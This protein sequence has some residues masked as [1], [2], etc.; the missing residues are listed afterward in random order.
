MEKKTI[1]T[2][3]SQESLHKKL[4][5]E[6]LLSKQQEENNYKTEQFG[7]L[8]TAKLN[9][10]KKL[11]NLNFPKTVTLE[12]K[13]TFESSKSVLMLASSVRAGWNGSATES[14]RDIEGNMVSLTKEEFRI[15]IKNIRISSTPVYSKE[16][17][18]IKEIGAITDLE[19]L[20][21]YGI[22]EKWEQL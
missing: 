14:W 19:T 12:G 3:P 5:A 13:G 7:T 11:R 20:K 18:I 2:P 9:E 4:N 6:E 1:A 16:G 22:K 10:A 8:K 21:A 15:L 17:I